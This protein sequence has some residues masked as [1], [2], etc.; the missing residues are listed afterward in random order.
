[1]QDDPSVK[2]VLNDAAKIPKKIGRAVLDAKVPVSSV[3]RLGQFLLDHWLSGLAALFV[4]VVVGTYYLYQLNENRNLCYGPDSY[5]YESSQTTVGRR[6]ESAL[7]MSPVLQLVS[8][9]ALSWNEGAWDQNFDVVAFLKVHAPEGNYGHNMGEAQNEQHAGRLLNYAFSQQYA[10]CVSDK[11]WVPLFVV[12]G[13]AI[14]TYFLLLFLA[15]V[16]RRRS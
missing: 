1:M 5:L 7:A 14:L 10:K 3:K 4:F 16:F 13:H 11:S 12:V 2:D 6:I 9:I 8:K 15:S